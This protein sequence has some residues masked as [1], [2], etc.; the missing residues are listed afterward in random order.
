MQKQPFK[1]KKVIVGFSGGVDSSVAA[2]L[3]KKEGYE[4]SGV[5]MKN[6]SET[7]DEEGICS[8]REDR[9]AA[10]RSAAFLGIPFEM[11]DF[12][13]EYRERV[14]EYMT[15]EYAL[16]HTP[17]P[18]V[19]CNREIKFGVFL[20]YA[21]DRGA[22]FIATGHYASVKFI[23]KKSIYKLYKGI[24]LSKDQAYFLHQLNQDQLSR[25]LFPLGE[26]YKSEVRRIAAKIGLP[27]AA[28][29]DSQGICF[30]GKVSMEEFLKKKIAPHKGP[31]VT[32]G[33]EAIGEHEGVEFYTIGQRKGIRVPGKNP[34]YV[35]ERK[36][37][38]N[39]LVVTDDAEDPRL[40]T[41]SVFCQDFHWIAPIDKAFPF[42]VKA[43]IRYHQ[44]DQSAFVSREGTRIRVDFDEPQWAVSH[45]QSAVLYRGRECLGGGVI[46]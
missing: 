27:N 16:A 17:N 10:L 9:D 26:Y 32:V 7:K 5:F 19:M 1:N 22:D 30:I 20:K 14:F 44:K 23:K 46:G 15:R 42:S 38:E 36:L 11:V 8:W 45:G 13:A 3:L 35:V 4:V 33:G 41:K 37:K 6:W 40:Y 39:V 24:D 31:I 25:T 12:E 2:Y 28:R 29:P 18:D 43:Q 21:M 34:Y